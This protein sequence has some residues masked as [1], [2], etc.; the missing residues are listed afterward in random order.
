M[1]CRVTKLSCTMLLLSFVAG[2]LGCLTR[3]KLGDSY[4]RQYRLVFAAQTRDDLE[5]QS[6]MTGEE[7]Q[8]LM[9][10]FR[11]E[12]ERGVVGAPAGQS[13]SSGSGQQDASF[14]I[15]SR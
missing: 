13:S 6:A 15:R 7:A 14:V 9:M 3:E 4:G 10:R 8:K 1:K 2:S 11:G 12:K 5:G